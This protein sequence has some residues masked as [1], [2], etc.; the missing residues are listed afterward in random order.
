MSASRGKADT[1][2]EGQGCLLTTHNGHWPVDDPESGRG[3]GAT[4]RDDEKTL[5]LF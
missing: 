1:D 5:P 4:R 3:T 2:C